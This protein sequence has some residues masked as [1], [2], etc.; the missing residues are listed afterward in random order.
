[1]TPVTQIVKMGEGVV[2]AVDSNGLL[3]LG[4]SYGLSSKASAET[5]IEWEP[6]NNP[7]DARKRL[8]DSPELPSNT[9]TG[10]NYK[11][12]ENERE[13]IIYFGTRNHDGKSG[14]DNS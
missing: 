10:R 3:W 5:E 7:P 6:V 8:K 13:D 4:R 12:G 14:S 2:L 1:M 9:I 11:P